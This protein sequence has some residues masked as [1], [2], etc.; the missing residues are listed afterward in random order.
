MNVSC[1]C[2]YCLSQP[3]VRLP[4]PLLFVSSRNDLAFWAWLAGVSPLRL[5]LMFVKNGKPNSKVARS[6]SEAVR[7]VATHIVGKSI[8]ESDLTDVKILYKG[9]DGGNVQL[10]SRQLKITFEVPHP[11]PPLPPLDE[12][13]FRSCICSRECSITCILSPRSPPLSSGK[14]VSNPPSNSGKRACVSAHEGEDVHPPYDLLRRGGSV[15]EIRSILECRPVWDLETINE[16]L[17]WG[18]RPKLTRV[19]DTRHT[20][21]TEVMCF[22]LHPTG[23]PAAPFWIPLS[24]LRS[25]YPREVAHI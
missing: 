20:R 13:T 7:F 3:C 5:V 25:I 2:V 23:V 1:Q 19:G 12:S 22:F 24:L 16:L 15:D 21:Y 4:V 6:V 17:R 8:S 11:V 18:A 9:K 14:R 10:L